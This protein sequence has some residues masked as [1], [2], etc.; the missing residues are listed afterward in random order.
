MK[1]KIKKYQS[2]DIDALVKNNINETWLCRVVRGGVMLMF[3]LKQHR[4]TSETIFI[5]PEGVHFK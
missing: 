5:V 2:A 1:Y 4:I 3:D